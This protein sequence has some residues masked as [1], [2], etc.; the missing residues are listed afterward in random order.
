MKFL[1]WIRKAI[2]GAVTTGA[3]ALFSRAADGHLD[4]D[5]WIFI[6]GSFVVGGVAVFLIPNRPSPN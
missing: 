5:D 3:A 6:A 2:T 4:T 1:A